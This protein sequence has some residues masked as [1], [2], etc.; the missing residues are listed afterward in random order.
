MK[1]TIIDRLSEI[2]NF[3]FNFEQITKE[4]L[5]LVIVLE[6]DNKLKCI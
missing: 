2:N 6:F 4:K 3:S 1:K 5:K